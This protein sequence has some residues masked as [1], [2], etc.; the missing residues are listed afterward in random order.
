LEANWQSKIDRYYAKQ[1][2]E[3]PRIKNVVPVGWQVLVEVIDITVRKT[4][5][6][7]LIEIPIDVDKKTE[8]SHMNVGKVLKIG[9]I[10]WSKYNN[11]PW[12]KEG[13][14]VY[15]RKYQGELAE[16]SDGRLLRLMDADDIKGIAELNDAEQDGE[17]Q[18]VG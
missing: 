12:Y 13:D 11:I 2:V 4:S 7:G 18:H 16:M 5:K 8:Q 15:F 14:Y 1:L 3:G 9:P 10:A 17:E 6:D